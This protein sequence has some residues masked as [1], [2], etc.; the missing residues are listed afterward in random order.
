LY[1]GVINCNQSILHVQ[2]ALEKDTSKFG[3]KVNSDFWFAELSNMLTAAVPTNTLLNENTAWEH[4]ERAM[5]QLNT[6]AWRGDIQAHLGVDPVGFQREIM[7]QALG[8]L[9]MYSQMRVGS[10]PQSAMVYLA[11]V[12]RIHRRCFIPMGNQA[13]MV[14]QVLNGMMTRFSEIYGVE[15][16]IPSRKEPFTNLQVRSLVSVPDGTQTK[17][18]PVDRNNLTWFSLF[19]IFHV[20]AQVGI[21]KDEAASPFSDVLPKRRPTRAWLT[22]YYQGT[23][24]PHLDTAQLA[25]LGDKDAAVLML[26]PSKADQH[27]LKWSASPY[28]LPF[29]KDAVICAAR[30]FRDLEVRFPVSVCQ[31]SKVPLFARSN[32]LPFTHTQLDQALQSVMEVTMTSEQRKCHSFHSFR[33]YLCACLYRAN[34]STE[35]IQRMLRWKAPESIA[36]YARE[37]V[38]VTAQW[39]DIAATQDIATIQVANLPVDSMELGLQHW[40]ANKDA[41]VPDESAQ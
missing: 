27:G 8:L 26:P 25:N 34:A 28:F 15:A 17:I 30:M 12:R 5:K 22:W 36:V 20:A 18:G 29:R 32:G 31:R 24:Y 16:L 13:D 1:V 7:V 4:W 2:E 9:I 38:Q 21:R 19:M 41:V 11:N 14:R 23:F 37:D 35:R 6:P 40:Y 10:K 3:I 39:L 33:I